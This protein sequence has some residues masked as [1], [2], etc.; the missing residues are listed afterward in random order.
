MSKNID[1]EI[2]NLDEKTPDVII[3]VKIPA[4][5]LCKIHQYIRHIVIPVLYCSVGYM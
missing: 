2:A 1:I 4:S 3:I 5:Q